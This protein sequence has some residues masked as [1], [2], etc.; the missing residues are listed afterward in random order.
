MSVDFATAGLLTGDYLE[1]GGVRSDHVEFG[2]GCV[3]SAAGARLWSDS[4]GVVAIAGQNYP[5]HWLDTLERHGIET[6]GVERIDQDHGLTLL[7]SDMTYDEAGER[8]EL[9]LAPDWSP[10]RGCAAASHSEAPT[11]LDIEEPFCPRPQSLPR[12]WGAKGLHLAP[13]AVGVQVAWLEAIS[14]ASTHI[15]LDSFWWQPGLDAQAYLAILGCIS[16]L[17][18]SRAEVSAFFDA[19]F[20]PTMINQLVD[21]GARIVAVK[22][23]RD[24]CALMQRGGSMVVVPSCAAQVLDP[25]G[26]GDAFCGGF[27]VGLTDTGDA[28][29]ATLQATVSASFAVEGVGLS[30]LLG[31]DQHEAHRRLNELRMAI[32]I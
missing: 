11:F 4:V 18:P 30:R 22:L 2:G 10:T 28:V 20:N 6:A 12:G 15:T 16:A 31:A 9:D 29:E 17:L 3:Y 24:G 26:A 25:T 1:I 23:G 19:A 5:E 32:D 21:L 8:P 14:A 13:M 27:L 7:A